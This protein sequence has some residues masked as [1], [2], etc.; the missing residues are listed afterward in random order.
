MFKAGSKNVLLTITE[1]KALYT[2]L[3]YIFE[4]TAG[5]TYS[6][7]SD[8]LLRS[9]ELECTAPVEAPVPVWAT[10]HEAS[11][12]GST[13]AIKF[14]KDMSDPDGLHGDFSVSASATVTLATAYIS[15]YTPTTI[16]LTT[17]DDLS[18]FSSITVAYSPGTVTSTDGGVLK[19]FS[20]FPVDTE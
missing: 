3:E 16:Y 2:D 18:D 12:A 19:A 1:A 20:E 6:R 13:I 8:Y 5:S 9:Q 15:A 14:S 4:G 17:T 10:I 11:S 7:M